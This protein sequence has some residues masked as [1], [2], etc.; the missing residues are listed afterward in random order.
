MRRGTARKAAFIGAYVWLAVRLSTPLVRLLIRT[1]SS[2]F[3]PTDP[4]K[5]MVTCKEDKHCI[6]ASFYSDFDPDEEIQQFISQIVVRPG[7]GTTISVLYA[8]L[9]LQHKQTIQEVEDEDNC[10]D[11]NGWGPKRRSS[12]VRSV[13]TWKPSG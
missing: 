2:S 13:Q 4:L 9:L 3:A 6:H 8:F 7:K 11:E 12:P 1:G 10:E 5:I